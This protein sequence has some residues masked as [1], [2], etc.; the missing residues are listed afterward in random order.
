[1]AEVEAPPRSTAAAHTG[2][3]SEIWKELGRCGQGGGKGLMHLKPRVRT[4]PAQCDC[5][6]TTAGRVLFR[7][8]DGDFT[9]RRVGHVYHTLNKQRHNARLATGWKPDPI[10]GWWLL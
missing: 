10:E 6:G 1:M 8:Y 4:W 2:L 3:G 9:G 7:L 5:R